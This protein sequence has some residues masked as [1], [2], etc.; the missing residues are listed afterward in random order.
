MIHHKQDS[1]RH[2]VFGE[3]SSK[4]NSNN[5]LIKEEVTDHEKDIRK[6]GGSNCGDSLGSNFYFL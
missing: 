4:N 2:E 3:K 6:D 5:K 1:E